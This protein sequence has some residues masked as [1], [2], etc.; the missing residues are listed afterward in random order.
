[1]INPVDLQWDEIAHAILLPDKTNS[2]KSRVLLVCRRNQLQNLSAW[3]FAVGFVWD[4]DD[5]SS[6]IPVEFPDVPSNPSHIEED[7]FCGGH[8]L[9]PEGD[10]VFVGGTDVLKQKQNPGAWGQKAIWLFV[11]D[12][13]NYHWLRLGEMSRERWYATGTAMNDGSILMTG[14]NS[15]PSATYNPPTKET[16]DRGTVDYNPSTGEPLG[17]IT[18]QP[19]MANEALVHLNIVKSLGDCTNQQA[20]VTIPDYPRM[21]SLGSGQ[22]FWTGR[23]AVNGAWEDWFLD[24]FACPLTST[25]VSHRWTGGLAATT[26]PDGGERGSDHLVDLS[27]A[28]PVEY[29]YDMAGAV[30]QTTF[31]KKVVRMVNPDTLNAVW[32]DTETVAPDLNL[33]VYDANFPIALDGSIL[34]IGGFW[35]DGVSYVQNQQ[36]PNIMDPVFVARRVAERFQPQGIFSSPAVGWKN[37]A[38]QAHGRFYHSTAVTLPNGKVLSAGGN[39]TDDDQPGDPI[40]QTEPNWWSAE[41]Y[42]PPYMFFGPRPRIASFPTAAITLGDPISISAILRTTSTAGEFRVTL[43]APGAATHAFDQNQK[44]FKLKI[45]GNPTISSDPN[46]ASTLSIAT[47][48]AG[49][50]AP[51]WYMLVVVNSAGVPSNAKWIRLKSS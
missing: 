17:T 33:E 11:N 1:V 29:V 46:A 47:P 26:P 34:R 32:D 5:P 51:G 41:V 15:E 28:S 24:L 13:A 49:S 35:W 40:S 3:P 42:S 31:S 10:V 20:H 8:T 2:G 19:L 21:H 27:G 39:D 45:V 30:N 16:F 36:N 12:P 38:E 44:F 4:A 37:M 7:P 6:P 14:H 48:S 23:K 18:W 22:V 25:S 9:T 43:L 50:T